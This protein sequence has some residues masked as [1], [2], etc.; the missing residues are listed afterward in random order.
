MNSSPSSPLQIRRARRED[1]PAIVRMMFDDPLG[2][3]R[4]TLQ[5]GALAAYEAAFTE[6]DA[7]PKQWLMVAE[8]AGEVIG[9]FQMTYLRYLSYQGGLRAQIEAVRVDARYRSQGIGR[10]MMAWAIQQAREQGCVLVQLATHKSRLDAHR[11]YARL[12]FV[13]SHEGMKLYLE[14][15]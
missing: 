12:G 4:E 5:A 6:I 13:A 8:M 7:D 15:H 14:P 1:V 11:F 9:T 2:S 10:Q 3:G